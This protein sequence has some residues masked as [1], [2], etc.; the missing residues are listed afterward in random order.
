MAC[1]ALGGT[2]CRQKRLRCSYFTLRPPRC[3]RD[4]AISA[5][6]GRIK[7]VLP[8][9]RGNRG[10]QGKGEKLY[11]NSGGADAPPRPSFHMGTF[12][13][14]RNDRADIE[15]LS[16]PRRSSGSCIGA[17]RLACV[18]P[19]AFSDRS[20]GRLTPRKTGSCIYGCGYS[21]GFSP[22]FLI[23]PPAEAAR[24]VTMQIYELLWL[25]YATAARV[26]QENNCITE[27]IFIRL[28]FQRRG[29]GG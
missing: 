15:K 17:K 10:G 14:P 24:K 28:R 27:R 2:P 3:Q 18:C 21:A 20:N 11:K 29:T 22:A 26:C 13:L 23:P 1:A 16:L 7:R 5:A 8:S 25:Y 12:S 9:S 6:K 4:A 19:L